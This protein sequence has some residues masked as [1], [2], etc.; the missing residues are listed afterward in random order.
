MTETLGQ[1]VRSRRTDMGLS[2]TAAAAMIGTSRG[3]LSQIELGTIKLPNPE[4]RRQ[5]ARLL[6]VSHLELL[7]A[8]GEIREDEL[9]SGQT[10]IAERTPDDPRTAIHALVDQVNWYGRPDRVESITS[11][12]TAYAESDA[13]YKEEL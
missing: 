12:L 10:G 4:L 2:L 7:I 13:R 1:F 8:A 6:G 5:I 3:T 9:A 11:I